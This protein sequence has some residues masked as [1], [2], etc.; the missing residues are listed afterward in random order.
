MFD[1][2]DHER[3]M[4]FVGKKMAE[5]ALRDQLRRDMKTMRGHFTG[6]MTKPRTEKPGKVKPLRTKRGPKPRDTIS[7][8]NLALLRKEGLRTFRGFSV[9]WLHFP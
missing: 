3:F 8:T 2:K 4:N 9:L 1:W 6:Q 5:Q 7:S